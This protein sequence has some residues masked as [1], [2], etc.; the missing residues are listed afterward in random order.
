MNLNVMS[1]LLGKTM[2]R[3]LGEERSTQLGLIAGMMPGLQGVMITALIAQREEPAAAPAPSD[4]K[5]AAAQLD[6]LKKAIEA[7]SGSAPTAP[8]AR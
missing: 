6:A 8:T 7:L 5:Q 2:A 1:F 4:P 3:D